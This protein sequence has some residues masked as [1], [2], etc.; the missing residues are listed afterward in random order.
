[1]PRALQE[2]LKESARRHK[3]L[4]RPAECPSGVSAA[5]ALGYP[6]LDDGLPGDA[7]AVGFFVQ[8]MNHPRREVHIH[9]L[10]LL[11]GPFRAGQVEILGDVAPESNSLSR[12]LAFI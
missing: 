5:Q 11:V 2:L 9:A 10:G 7:Q 8:G 6:N 4:V 1:M 3:R 12:S